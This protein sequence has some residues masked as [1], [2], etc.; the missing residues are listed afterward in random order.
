MTEA[1]LSSAGSAS[2]GASGSPP[3]A[4]ADLRDEGPF[5]V[6]AGPWL[7]LPLSGAIRPGRWVRLRYRTSLLDDAVRP[8]L[9]FTTAAGAIQTEP[10]TG[11]L[12]GSGEWTGRIP[13]G[14][15]ALAV[16]SGSRQ[17]GGALEVL[18]LQAVPLSRVLRRGMR[19]DRGRA[20]LSLGIWL[21]ADRPA[22]ERLLKLLA[23]TAPLQEYGSWR[24]GLVRPLDIPGCDAPRADWSRTP[25][26][27][28]IARLAGAGPDEL[29]RTLAS[30]NSQAYPRWSLAFVPEG[31]SRA[32]LD[33][34]GAH[35]ATDPR[36]VAP[37]PALDPGPA[38]TW[39][40]E[41]RLG[42]TLP[43]HALAAVAELAA[44]APWLRAAY[45]DEEIVDGEGRPLAPRL[46]PDWSPV[47]LEGEDYVGRL[48]LVRA[49]ALA[50]A[51]L[52][53]A[54]LARDPTA[55]LRRVLRGAGDGEVGHLRRILYRRM[56]GPAP[57]RARAGSERVW[58]PSAD[59]PPAAVVIPVRDRADLLERCAEG[60]LHRTS[61][62]SLE[63]LVIDNG[64]R[65]PRT[66]ALL[67][68]LA[69]DPRVTVMPRPGP[70]NYAALCNEGAAAT[71]PPLLLFLNSDIDVIGPDWLARLADLAIR[72]QVGAVGAKLL[73]PDGSLQHAGVTVGL[74]GFAGHLYS[75]APR[76]EPGHLGELL[77]P[78]EVS[79]VT[80][81]CLAVEREKFDAVGGYDA[82][83]LPVDLNDVDLCL[84]LGERGWRTVWTPHA[85]LYHLES[86][87]RGRAIRGS[88]VYSKER[89]YFRERW[90]HVI[91][92]DP[93]YHPALSLVAR[94]PV[95]G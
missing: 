40:G 57:T 22:G 88:K 79:A 23:T 72:P 87:S 77:V 55:T 41:I 52:G 27:R 18:S 63:V 1:F 46:K 26:I 70:F 4:P 75:G 76:D 25:S 50:G 59:P 16:S 73:Y 45:G 68:R 31:A 37:G 71:R 47:F 12:W 80:G 93:Y 15:V 82:R 7:D 58:L 39:W 65:E 17:E 91:R 43:E 35:A 48:A 30:L 2:A 32:L 28:L 92:D 54:D 8:L 21:F 56:D 89:A 74:N 20:L 42:D 29:R 60:L 19:R 78:H 44:R 64:S 85:E 81:A 66:H 3:A 33:A 95:L 5:P 10:L 38:G 83:N 67:E 62:P 6:S 11:A 14:T 36:I 53:P 51:G 94:S 9:R 84:R 90:A 49:E 13:E 69:A 24:A 61:Y 34:A 86:A